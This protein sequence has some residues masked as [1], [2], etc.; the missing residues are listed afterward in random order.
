MKIFYFATLLISLA[1]CSGNKQLQQQPIEIGE[2]IKSGR[3]TFHADMAYPS[4]MRPRTINPPGTL[5]Q[6]NDT[7]E[8]ALPYFGRAQTVMQ[9]EPGGI[10]FSTREFTRSVAKNEAGNW[11]VSYVIR[12][13]SSAEEIILTIYDNRSATVHVSSLRRDRIQFRGYV[14]A[15]LR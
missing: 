13:E 12:N 1:A 14:Q 2:A 4:A 3:F 15:L 6:R 8:V 10:D 7:L 9:N 5:S 11:V